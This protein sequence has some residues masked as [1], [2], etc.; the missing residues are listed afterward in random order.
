MLDPLC[1]AD[2]VKGPRDNLTGAG[3]VIWIGQPLFQQLGVS[4]NDAQLVVQLMEQL[5]E[6]W[7]RHLRAPAQRFFDPGVGR[8]RFG[9][10]P[11]RV[12]KDPHGATGGPDVMDLSAGHPVV[13]GAA[14]HADQFTCAGD[15]NCLTLDGV[16]IRLELSARA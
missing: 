16:H 15:G 13:D 11:Q 5:A 14:A 1:R 12:G 3:L 4:E 2:G 10:S 9:P 7:L 8:R 6:F